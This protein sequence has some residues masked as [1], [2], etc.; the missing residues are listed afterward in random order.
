MKIIVLLVI[1]LILCFGCTQIPPRGE[2]FDDQ[3]NLLGTC[4]VETKT[5]A[6]GYGST[7]T[8]KFFDLEGNLIG[9]CYAYHGPGSSGCG[10]DGCDSNQ[11]TNEPSGSEPCG[12]IAYPKYSCIIQ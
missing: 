4:E 2:Y 9:S 1:T 8:T 10:V 11:L 12:N 3:G 5:S 7:T 6:D